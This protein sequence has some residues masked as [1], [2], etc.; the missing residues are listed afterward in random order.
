MHSLAGSSDTRPALGAW[1]PAVGIAVAGAALMLAVASRPQDPGRAA[2]VF[3]PWWGGGAA[4]A[5]A[6]RAG[7]VIAVGAVPFI[8]I[9]QAPAGDA[10]LRLRRAGAL[11]SIDPRGVVPCGEQGPS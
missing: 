3:P 10:A 4:M 9:V 6:S 5:A 2:G 1:L 8:V 7:D 11:F